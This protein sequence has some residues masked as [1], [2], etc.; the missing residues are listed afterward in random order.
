MASDDQTITLDGPAGSGKT[1]V[2]RLLAERLGYRFLDTGAMYRACALAALSAGAAAPRVPAADLDEAAVSRAVD[3]AAIGLDAF[4]HVAMGGVPLGDEIRSLAVTET[5]SAVS[6][7][8]AVRSRMT[9]LQREFGRRSQPGLVAEGRDM[10]TVVFPR[11]RHRF[12]LDA[13]PEIRGARRVKDWRERGI[14]PV[15]TLAEAISQLRH[16]DDADSK[17][18]AAPLR[19]GTGVTVVDTSAL[20][21]DQVVA[22]LADLVASAFET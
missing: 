2:A 18:E 5:V 16:R 3:A 7:L 15:P 12:Y 1:T 13:S 9:A 19:I 21:I 8:P 20:G 11:A 6:A 14:D 4:G 22:H 10:A 17:R